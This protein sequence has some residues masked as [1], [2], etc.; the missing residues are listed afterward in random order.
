[1]R[2]KKLIILFS[3]LLAITLL[4][5]FNSVLFSVQHVDVYCA[6]MEKSQYEADVLNSHKIR[7]GSSIF[8]VNKAKVTARVEKAVPGIRVLNIEKKFPNRIYINYIEVPAYVKVTSG[9]KTYYLG[10]DMRVMRIEDGL[11]DNDNSGAIRLLYGGTLAAYSVGE[12]L[13]FTTASGQNASVLVSA[14]FASMEKLG[15]YDTVIDFFDN[16]DLSGNYIVLTTSTG[17]KWKMFTA[18]RL[19]DKIQLAYSVYVN[20]LTEL[21][22]REG[23]LEIS[24]VDK[25]VANY[26]GPSGVTQA[27]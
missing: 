22:R 18:D 5:V 19:D 25:L 11:G 2:N 13:T 16:I 14:I 10:N 17:L 27:V 20:E 21:Q 8:F 12:T 26:S 4:V 1:M 23:T 3:V 24:G 15:Y 6:N 7:R 9:S